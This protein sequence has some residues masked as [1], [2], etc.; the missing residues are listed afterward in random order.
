V[1]PLLPVRGTGIDGG[2]TNANGGVTNSY[3]YSAYGVTTET[4]A[5][6]T[7]V[8]NPWRYAG[9]Y[10][11]TTTGLYKMGARYYQA[12]LGRWTQRDPSGQDANAYLYVGGNPINLTDATGLN[13]VSCLFDAIGIKDALE[14]LLDKRSRSSRPRGQP[15]RR[16]D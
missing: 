13:P 3:T 11:D 7:N 9:Q 2:G 1:A 16:S 12:E 15:P 8:F 10:Q 14:D 4:K 5:A 6:L